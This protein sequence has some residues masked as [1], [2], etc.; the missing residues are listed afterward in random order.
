MAFIDFGEYLLQAVFIENVRAVHLLDHLTG[1]LALT[2]ARQLNL[3]AS[4]Q[5]SGVDTLLHQLLVDL[6]N[7]GSLVAVLFNAL[8]SHGKYSS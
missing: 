1:S 4:L 7:N 8:D 2:E 3:L 6:D 5:V